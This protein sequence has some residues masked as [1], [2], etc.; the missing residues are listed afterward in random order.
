MR[1]RVENTVLFVPEVDQ[2]SIQSHRRSAIFR[3]AASRTMLCPSLS[4]RTRETAGRHRRFRR[5]DL[6]DAIVGLVEQ[7]PPLPIP[8]GGG[9]AVSRSRAETN[10]ANFADRTSVSAKAIVAT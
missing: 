2:V 3:L 9:M 8:L 6:E 7:V 1:Y 4:G 5:H 10:D